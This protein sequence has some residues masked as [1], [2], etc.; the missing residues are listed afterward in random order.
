MLWIWISVNSKKYQVQ[1][2]TQKLSAHVQV[3]EDV[4]TT[5]V[6]IITEHG[7][8]AA[9]SSSRIVSYSFPSSSLWFENNHFTFQHQCLYS[10]STHLLH[11]SWIID[12]GATSHVCSYLLMFN[13]KFSF[14]DVTVSLLNDTRVAITH[15][16]TV[17]ISS[18]LVLH[19][20]L[21]VTSFKFN[22][23]YVSSLLQSTNCS[24]HFYADSC[25][26]QECSQ[27][28]RGTFLHNLYNLIYYLLLSTSLDL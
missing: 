28:E 3:S 6:A 25:F 16:G 5:F 18:S 17:H 23:I 14:S 27:V 15:T 1:S 13:E 2:L 21:H 19:N 7:V 10:L 12:N 22:L 20:F 4:S 26:I 8:M 11:D 24:A 9:Q